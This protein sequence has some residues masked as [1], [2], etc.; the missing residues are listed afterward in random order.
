MFWGWI[1]R[2]KTDNV[3]RIESEK[4]IVW[5]IVRENRGWTIHAESKRSNGRA[6]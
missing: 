6:R 5:T 4:V 2:S 1:G 3:L